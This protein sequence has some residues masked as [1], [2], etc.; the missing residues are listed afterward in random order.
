MVISKSEKGFRIA[1]YQYLNS[2][3]FPTFLLFFFKIVSYCVEAQLN[4]KRYGK[5]V[6]G[7]G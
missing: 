4:P 3:E 7:S 5:E 1:I 6:E 2:S